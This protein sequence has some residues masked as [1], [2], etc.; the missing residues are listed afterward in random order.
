M[1]DG[2]PAQAGPKGLFQTV[3]LANCY[4]AILKNF[5]VRVKVDDDAQLSVRG[6][7]TWPNSD[8]ALRINQNEV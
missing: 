2:S 3:F 5:L 6:T 7:A 1:G 8:D 4:G